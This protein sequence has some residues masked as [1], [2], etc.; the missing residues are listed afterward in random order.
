MDAIERWLIGAIV[1]GASTSTT[2][3]TKRRWRGESGED[4]NS[5]TTTSAGPY[6]L[7]S[8]FP[9]ARDGHSE[10]ISQLA[11]FSNLFFK[12][13]KSLN[14]K[15]KYYS[16]HC[17][18][19]SPSL[20]CQGP[21]ALHRRHGGKHGAESRQPDGDVGL[22]RGLLCGFPILL[23]QH[24]RGSDHHHLPGAGRQDDPRV[25]SGEKR[26]KRRRRAS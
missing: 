18:N 23:R 17:S 13:I 26:G 2:P 16:T 7:S 5:T 3:E 21:S 1:T 10:S 8:P 15:K 6:W 20:P 11:T 9:R 4:M 14:K 24:L 25:Q 22:L 19:S 12:N